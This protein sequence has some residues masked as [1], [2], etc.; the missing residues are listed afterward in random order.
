M[1]KAEA[2]KIYSEV[3]ISQ[4]EHNSRWEEEYESV[5][6]E[7][8]IIYA[9]EMIDFANKL[10]IDFDNDPNSYIDKDNDWADYCKYDNM[11]SELKDIIDKKLQDIILA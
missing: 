5:Q 7:S 10:N 4:S 8:S 3:Q 2:L 9:N 11:G 1:N 6:E